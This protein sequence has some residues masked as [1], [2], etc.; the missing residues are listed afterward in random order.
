MGTKRG[1]GVIEM[2]WRAQRVFSLQ[3]SLLCL[4]IRCRV[5]DVWHVGPLWVHRSS[6][7]LVFVAVHYPPAC[8]K[9]V[10]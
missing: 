8:N 6:T 2:G 9:R 10:G 7:R 1:A 5:F 4:G 3:Y